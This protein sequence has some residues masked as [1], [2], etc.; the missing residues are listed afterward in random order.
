MTKEY[1]GRTAKELSA[2]VVEGLSL[3]R[4]YDG[5][6]QSTSDFH[7]QSASGVEYKCALMD[8]GEKESECDL[9]RTFGHR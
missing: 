9:C 8:I 4:E 7:R 3:S 6:H 1:R 2:L 5:E